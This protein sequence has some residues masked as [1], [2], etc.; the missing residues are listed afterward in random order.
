MAA[1]LVA[2]GLDPERCTLFV[3]SHRPEH[4]ELAWLLADRHA[5]QLA[6]AHA[7]LQGE[8]APTSPTTSTTAC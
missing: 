6:G 7:D 1:S 3:Q 4:T 2:L 5:G 8:E